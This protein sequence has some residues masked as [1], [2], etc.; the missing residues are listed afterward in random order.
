MVQIYNKSAENISR[1]FHN[2]WLAR[3]PQPE[4]AIHDNGKEFTG[5][6]FQGLLEK[7]G[8]KPYNTTTKNPQSN[9]SFKQMNQRVA[10]ILKMKIKASSTQNVDKVNNLVEEV[11]ASVMHSICATVS[12]TFK[13]P[14]GR[15]ASLA[16]FY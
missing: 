12:T 13:A 11:L 3:Y 6:E 4:H 15:L 5:H 16:T 10:M 7:L 9:A 1:S 2:T 8:I 14:P